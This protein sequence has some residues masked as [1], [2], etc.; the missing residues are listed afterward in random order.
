MG[1]FVRCSSLMT[2]GFVDCHTD[3]L[4][5]LLAGLRSKFDSMQTGSSCGNGVNERRIRTMN[6][7]ANDK[8]A[9]SLFT[10]CVV[11]AKLITAICCGFV[12]NLLYS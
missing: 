10:T 6:V 12:V 1:K 2:P 4:T 9:A 7:V 11:R 3:V 8:Y 5:Y